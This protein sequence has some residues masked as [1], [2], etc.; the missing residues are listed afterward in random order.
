MARIVF[1]PFS[2]YHVI[3]SARESPQR[4]FLQEGKKRLDS[5]H[6]AKP[7]QS[8]HTADTEGL[9]LPEA[10]PELTRGQL[11]YAY[12]QPSFNQVS[13]GTSLSWTPSALTPITALKV[14]TP[15]GP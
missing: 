12:T 15:P 1:F 2:N 13:T 4:L 9:L 6:E 5:M 10:A 8:Q 3:E 11:H 7:S 14:N